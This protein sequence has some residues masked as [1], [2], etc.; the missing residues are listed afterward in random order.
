M[1]DKKTAKKNSSEI[2]QKI[3]PKISSLI[4]E[5]LGPAA[6]DAANNR[7]IMEFSTSKIYVFMPLPF[8]LLLTKEKFVDLCWNYRHTLFKNVRSSDVSEPHAVLE[9]NDSQLEQ[10][11]KVSDRTE[12]EINK[13]DFSNIENKLLNDIKVMIEDD[14][15]ID[16][17]EKKILGLKIK[18]Y[19]ISKEQYT[20]LLI[21]AITDSDK[22]TENEKSY[23]KEFEFC[24]NGE[25]KIDSE[26]R[27]VLDRMRENYS[28]SKERSMELEK[29]FL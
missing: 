4:T 22:F 1:K 17:T 5:K 9:S 18:K 16:E 2:F 26:N 19:S 8:R 15:E 13:S 12:I 7:E 11:I 24:L 6:R 20:N 3:L 14:G 27:R 10:A 25:C 23:F 28:V 29:M 21:K